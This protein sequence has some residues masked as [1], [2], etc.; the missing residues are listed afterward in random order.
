[1]PYKTEKLKIDCPFIERRTKLMPCQKE[2]DVYWHNK[3]LSQRKIASMFNVS[4]RLIIFIV[5]PE[6]QKK[7]YEARLERGGSMQ[8][9]KKEKNNEYQK[10]HRKYKHEILSHTLNLKK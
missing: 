8:Y 9:Y 5:F 3:G 7:N 1:M 4:R 10:K 2:M 6:R